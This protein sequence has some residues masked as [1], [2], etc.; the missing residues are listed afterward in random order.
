MYLQFTIKLYSVC[1]TGALTAKPFSLNTRPWDIDTFI[2]KVGKFRNTVIV[3]IDNYNGVPN[4]ISFF[5]KS[6]S[7]VPDTGRITSLYE[8]RLIGVNHRL[9]IVSDAFGL[10]HFCTTYTTGMCIGAKTL[11]VIDDSSFKRFYEYVLGI[12]TAEFA[13]KSKLLSFLDNQ[14]RLLEF[15]VAY[16][17]LCVEGAQ[18]G[19]IKPKLI[20]IDTDESK[21]LL[22]VSSAGEWQTLRVCCDYGLLTEFG[23]ELSFVVGYG[24]VLEDRRGEVTGFIT[25]ERLETNERF[26]QISIQNVLW[27]AYIRKELRVILALIS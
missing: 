1:C 7:W 5:R 18:G 9:L 11:F 22:G 13:S 27:F 19:V 14:G 8:K 16:S 10:T 26:L 24:S 25:R 20:H 15:I 21:L 2:V 3:G 6:P 17:P 4:K 12:T 23:M